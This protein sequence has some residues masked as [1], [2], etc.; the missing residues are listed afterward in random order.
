MSSKRGLTRYLLSVNY[1]PGIT[2][3]PCICTAEKAW[4][5]HS[6]SPHCPPGS[7]CS[8]EET[9]A[10]GNQVPPGYRAGKVEHSTSRETMWEASIGFS[11]NTSSPAGIGICIGCSPLG[12][13][14][15]LGDVDCSEAR[16]H[17][18]SSVL[19]GQP[20]WELPSACLHASQHTF[21][22]LKPQTLSQ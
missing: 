15:L 8:T 18:Q 17:P 12:G 10:A 2:V 7:D 22:T 9:P 13:G 6:G 1:E 20:R 4:C 19:P 16:S 5:V 11:L 21:H 3:R 14:A